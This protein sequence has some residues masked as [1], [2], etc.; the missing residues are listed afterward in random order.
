VNVSTTTLCCL[1]CTQSRRQVGN[2][3]R[4]AVGLGPGLFGVLVRKAVLSLALCSMWS[5]CRE[6]NKG[7]WGL[8][9]KGKEEGD[10]T[11]IPG[12]RDFGDQCL[13]LRLHLPEPMLSSPKAVGRLTGREWMQ[14]M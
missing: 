14:R 4:I 1:F 9:N 13:R 12:R 7:L 10:P 6:A 2:K 5:G 3:D 8:N 11:E